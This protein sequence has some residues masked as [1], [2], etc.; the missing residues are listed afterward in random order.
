MALSVNVDSAKREAIK[1]EL[2]NNQDAAPITVVL[3]DPDVTLEE[4]QALS[5]EEKAKFRSAIQAQKSAIGDDIHTKLEAL[6]VEAEKPVPAASSTTLAAASAPAVAQSVSWEI[7]TAAG[8]ARA[9]MESKL[10]VK[11][12]ANARDF[13]GAWQRVWSKVPGTE[14][15]DMEDI[16][17]AINQSRGFNEKLIA[18][19]VFEYN[20]DTTTLPVGWF[21][22]MPGWFPALQKNH[23]F[24]TTAYN[25]K[26]WVEG[27]RAYILDTMN[28]LAL[29]WQQADTSSP[30][31]L[32]DTVE[33]VATWALPIFGYPALL[34]LSGRVVYNM[35]HNGIKKPWIGEAAGWSVGKV[36]DGTKWVVTFGKAKVTT[37]YKWGSSKYSSEVEAKNLQDTPA[38]SADDWMKE[39][40][41]LEE[42]TRRMIYM[43]SGR[44]PRHNP[45]AT[46]AE[47]FHDVETTPA[48]KAAFDERMVKL[49]ELGNTLMWQ[50]KYLSKADFDKEAGRV[51][52][53]DIE[54]A[55]LPTKVKRKIPWTAERKEF[56]ETQAALKKVKGEI[57]AMRARLSAKSMMDGV[58]VPKALEAQLKAFEDAYK[59]AY[60]ADLTL[61]RAWNQIVRAGD[62]INAINEVIAQFEEIATL[63]GKITAIN[64]D[65]TTVEWRITAQRNAAHTESPAEQRQR[66]ADGKQGEIDVANRE[67]EQAIRE[68]DNHE[69]AKREATKDKRNAE[70]AVRDEENRIRKEISDRKTVL[71]DNITKNSWDPTKA[72]A[73][74]EWQDE[75]NGNRGKVKE[76]TDQL[77]PP[78]TGSALVAKNQAVKDAQDVYDGLTAKDAAVQRKITDAEQ[79]VSRLAAEKTAILSRPAWADAKSLT[80]S[81]QAEL[82]RL[83]AKK[84]ELEGKIKE[85]KAAIDAIAVKPENKGFPRSA[86]GN[87]AQARAELAR[88][89]AL[90]AP[91]GAL[92]IAKTNA[93]ALRDGAFTH[94][95]TTITTLNTESARLGAGLEVKVPHIAEFVKWQNFSDELSMRENGTTGDKAADQK[96]KWSRPKPVETIIRR[97]K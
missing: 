43:D 52:A 40:A 38:Y 53:G 71:Q 74:G 79:K 93:K 62:R 51:V 2:I 33:S 75:L 91:G 39:R 83:K 28:A 36:W 12:D 20:Q 66:E 80:S 21:S 63:E 60:E 88:I 37:V 57:D 10:L 35:A 5:P 42:T 7:D 23:N 49:T 85:K 19:L 18:A 13:L 16:S 14:P 41:R 97:G 45:N 64:T 78:Y 54:K 86:G 69:T 6:V 70:Q 30:E 68:S 67:R 81:D 92:D 72:T 77:T 55:D 17:D 90:V 11:T 95:N 3:A 32:I 58:E 47:I 48:L 84:W 44:N 61:D 24:G 1:N 34:L 56:K 87:L 76:L 46:P 31:W 82:D 59:K 73:V 4:M 89:E 96:L 27:K 15:A 65:I 26:T 29:K 22:N 25:W 50:E 94:L 9:A 8:R